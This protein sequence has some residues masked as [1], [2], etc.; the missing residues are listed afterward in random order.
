M[1]FITLSGVDGSGKSTQL[2]LLRSMLEARDFQVA[3]FH[4]VSFSLVETVRARLFGSRSAGRSGGVT[5]TTELGLFFR[6]CFLLV[7]LLR[8][9][10]FCRRL[11][12]RGTDYLIS[13]RSFYD[14][15]INIAFL[16]GTSLDT[17][18]IRFAFRHTV[19]PDV[20]CYL[21]VTPERVM[22]RVRPPEQGLQYLKDKTSLFEEATQRFGLTV[23]DADQDIDRVAEDIR[24]LILR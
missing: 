8:F 1:R 15:F 18:F 12:K 7:D 21:R 4:A 10:R 19:R 14:S 11:E 16:G 13:D 24:S 22:E 5:K 2:E 17:A 3:S 6:K 9:R 20:A 23:I